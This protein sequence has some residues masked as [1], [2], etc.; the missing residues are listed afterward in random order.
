MT[1]PKESLM[2]TRPRGRDTVVVQVDGRDVDSQGAARSRVFLSEWRTKS[3]VVREAGA[4]VHVTRAGML[5]EMPTLEPDEDGR[6]VPTVVWCRSTL[7]PSRIIREAEAFTSAAGRS[8]NVPAAEAAL[9]AALSAMN[10][11]PSWPGCLTAVFGMRSS[12]RKQ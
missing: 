4:L 1:E 8:L 3:R 10:R 6:L 9:Q 5:L 7:E 12:R 11:T 2:L